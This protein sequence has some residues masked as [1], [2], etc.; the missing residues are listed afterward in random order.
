MSEKIS[1]LPTATDVTGAIVPIVQG[2]VNKK[3]DASLFS[4]PIYNAN[5]IPFGDG[6]T[7]GGVTDA[8]FAIDLA[9]GNFFAGANAGS[10]NTGINVVAVGL[11]AAGLN[12]GT[13][14]VA[15]GATAANANTGNEVVAVGLGVANGNT[16]NNVVAVGSGTAGSNTGDYVVSIGA[17]AGTGNTGNNVVAIGANAGTGNSLSGM[18]I[19]ANT[20]LPSYA[21]Y[22]AAAAAISPTG[23]VGN[24]YIYHDQ[25]TD[26]IGAVRL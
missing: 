9:N 10:S 23:V 4:A 21:D 17:N 20:E 1:A 12:T 14:V 25:A 11:G 19:I 6:T 2:G 8:G 22:T 26:S 5:E 13:D 16:G 18:F 3:A 15:V 24:T 7:A